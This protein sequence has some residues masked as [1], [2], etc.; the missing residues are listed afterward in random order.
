VALA[1]LL[2]RPGMTAPIIGARTVD[3]LR[4]V[5]GAVDLRLTSDEIAALDGVT[6]K[7]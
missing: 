7:Y 1:W 6:K 2:Q 3:Q 5:I 4:E